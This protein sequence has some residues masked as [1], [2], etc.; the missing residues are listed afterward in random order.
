MRATVAAVLCLCAG[1]ALAQEGAPGVGLPGPRGEQGPAGAAGPKGDQ[2]IP[3]TPGATGMA[4]PAGAQGPAGPAGATGAIGP[5][6]PAGN[7]GATGA[8]GAAGPTGLTGAK[9]DK[10]DVGPA[11]P[12]GDTGA[13]GD[14]GPQ[15][16]QG[17][18]GP[19][20]STFVCNTTITETLLLA[21]SAGIRVSPSATCA[22]VLTTDIL[23]VY[24]T[25]FAS[26]TD[27]N[28]ASKGLAVHHLFPTAA[29]QVKAIL[30]MP[31]LALGASYSIPVAIYAINR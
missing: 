7:S 6:G 15:G 2:G 31:A 13:K 21:V 23:E 5:T 16:Q 28:G 17:P 9:G 4:G 29:G 30:S 1:A 25:S 20:A 10:G 14:Q 24:P 19:K 11:G 26:L 18:V 27:A 3:G 22:G 8:T 12:K